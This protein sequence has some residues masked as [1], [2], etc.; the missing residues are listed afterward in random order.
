MAAVSSAASAAAARIGAALSDAQYFE[1]SMVRVEDIRRQL[2]S[3]SV[4]EKLD[5][6]KRVVALI[7]LGKDASTFFPDVVKNV[8]APSLDVKK[9][10]Y[11]YLVH[12]AEEKQDLALLAINS[13]QKDLSDHNQHIRALSLRVLSSIRVRVILQVV[14]LAISKAAKDSSSY[15]RKAAAHAIGKVC[16]LDSASKEVLL[17]PLQ[18]LISDRS[19]QVMGSAI[20]AFEEVCPYNFSLIHPHYRR[21]CA[22]LADVD[23]WGQ[24]TIMNMLLRY[25]RI[26]FADP[27]ASTA[28]A[29]RSVHS[30]NSD[31]T[32][33]LTNVLPLFYSMNNGVVASAIAMF[34]HLATKDE[35]CANAVK[36]LMR[37]V[38]I[39]DDG[40]QAVALNMAAAVVTRFPPALLPYVSELYVSAAHSA[41]IRVLRMT[42]LTR[43]CAAAD[44]PGGIG[45][46]PH[47]RRALLAELKEY[48]FRS[49]KD[50]AAASAR[51]IGSLA[52]AHPGST[53]AI[54][55]VLSSIVR[56]A[57]SPAVVT[58]AIGVLRK[59]L[60][61]HPSAQARALP[62]LIALLLA[63][64]GSDRESIQEPA[65]R[66][67]V[68]WLI[69]EF[70]DKVQAVA[71]EALRL[72]AR[73]FVN[74]AAEVKLQILNLAA[75]AVAWNESAR[76][77]EAMSPSLPPGV[78][79]DV[80]LRLLE[81]VISCAKYD[82]DYDVRDKARMFHLLFIT[83]TNTPLFGTVCKAFC[84]R[85]PI[86][87]SDDVTSWSMN[88]ANL[89]S[90]VVIGSLTQ[91]L[92][93]RR[94]AGFQALES[95]AKEDSEAALRDEVEGGGT[96][97]AHNREYTGVSSADFGGAGTTAN[98]GSTV[99]EPPMGIS[100]S[101]VNLTGATGHGYNIG[102]LGVDM[103]SRLAGPSLNMKNVDPERFYESEGTSGSSE[104][105]SSSE[106][107]DDEGAV[108]S[109]G[110]Q[111][112]AH[113]NPQQVV[114]DLI[115]TGLAERSAEQFAP[116]KSTSEYDIEALLGSLSV[117]QEKSEN[118]ISLPDNSPDGQERSSWTRLV[119]TWRSNGL[120]IDACYIRTPSAAGS[121][122]TPVV[123]RLTNH[124]NT[125]LENISFSS[126][127]GTYFA[128]RKEL[129]SLP[130]HHSDEVLA[131]VRFRGKTTGVQFGVKVD[132]ADVTSGELKPPVGFVVRP[133]IA[134]TPGA[135]LSTEQSLRGMFGNECTVRLSQPEGSDWMGLSN[136]I[137][138]L[139]LEK[140]FLSHVKTSVG[141]RSAADSEK[142]SIALAGHLPTPDSGSQGLH[143]VLVR[144]T[145]HSAQDEQTCKC[146]LWV[147][148]EVML[149]S[150]TLMQACKSALV[151][152]TQ[153]S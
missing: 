110:A 99:W 150:A 73:G 28:D 75:K 1:S 93:G 121:D 36:P 54:V 71:T 66:S 40:G 65:A 26:H 25:A 84:A 3:R 120:E 137:R 87:A 82:R 76:T 119:E 34:Y 13:F 102:S 9:L 116:A 27:S 80:R 49:D 45:S 12:Y 131:N 97:A 7:S 77:G 127:S 134:I 64:E 15:V 16:A 35:F 31:L 2:D 60:Q 153:P 32:L 39:E 88:I 52:T 130:P 114:N 58:E 105:D 62:Q 20:A 143:P 113:P 72:L 57:N 144:L 4:K 8:V 92:T 148:C 123:L 79:E 104:Y 133:N 17:E 126:H 89:E 18:D 132:A 74:E 85:K 83:Q 11:L 100:S 108:V 42:V 139:I 59:L 109:L 56:S 145:V 141:G 138:E 94:L 44:K 33:L 90:D 136:L 129:P 61:R 117:S 10:V 152:L 135:F 107:E 21:M 112:F 30:R 67:S 111:L 140:C 106:E 124:G 53:P 46:M 78:P 14:I 48:L 98:H 103:S 50:L 47:A 69:G 115:D 38:D 22:S 81:Y 118:K 122:V 128:A 41:P 125:T 146:Q 147:G 149:F 86:P 55:K 43:I 96:G 5:A 19:T 68:I 51:A 24:I 37:L 101:T 142:F 91:V 6:M 23:P 63:G 95:W 70:Y 151:P 29:Q